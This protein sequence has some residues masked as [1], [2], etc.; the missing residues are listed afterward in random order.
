MA[1]QGSVTMLIPLYMV[2]VFHIEPGRHGSIPLEV[3]WRAARLAVARRRDELGAVTTGIVAVEVAISKSALGAWMVLVIVPVLIVDSAPIEIDARLQPD[4][5]IA[6]NH[7]I[8][9]GWAMLRWA[10][11]LSP[12]RTPGTSVPRTHCRR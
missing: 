9:R 1:F 6:G 3:A 4:V 11:L 12:S 5:C 2:G 10:M 7:I 8:L